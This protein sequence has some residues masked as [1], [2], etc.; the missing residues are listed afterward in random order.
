MHEL[1][2][3][4]FLVFL[5]AVWIASGTIL[6]VDQF[7]IRRRHD[8]LLHHTHLDI[9]LCSS[10]RDRLTQLEPVEVVAEH[11][12]V[13][14]LG[15]RWQRPIDGIALPELSAEIR[16]FLGCITWH[17]VTWD[18]YGCDSLPHAGTRPRKSHGSRRHQQNPVSV[19]RLNCCEL[20]PFLL[21]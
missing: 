4:C 10:N 18:D 13:T 16:K 3:R 7:G 17:L 12:G 21:G 2:Y 14:S 19:S 15:C 8:F 11:T 6:R 1:V 20:P 5:Q 9:A